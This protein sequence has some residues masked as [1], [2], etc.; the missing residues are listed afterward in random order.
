MKIMELK[1]PNITCQQGHTDT[2]MLYFS[3]NLS[4]FSYICVHCNSTEEDRIKKLR[5]LDKSEDQ[6]K[7]SV[8]NLNIKCHK[9][10]K[11][12]ENCYIFLRLFPD[13]DV[14]ETFYYCAICNL[15]YGIELVPEEVCF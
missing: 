5:L 1:D 9:N 6:I 11:S 7:L 8:E 14:T 3:P 4:E 12:N 2:L 15:E 13:I 10:H